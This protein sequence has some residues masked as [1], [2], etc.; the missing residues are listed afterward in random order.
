MQSWLPPAIRVGQVVTQRCTALLWDTSQPASLAE[1]F[2]L[3]VVEAWP[4]NS[5]AVATRHYL[6]VTDDHLAKATQKA[7]QNPVQSASDS[8]RQTSKVNS[9]TTTKK[10]EMQR[11]TATCENMQPFK[12]GDEGL[13]PYSGNIVKHRVKWTR[14]IE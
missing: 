3:H 11:K 10:P 9:W 6:Q 13:K 12:V 7:V 14:Q 5:E 4:G 8:R 2:P 1:D